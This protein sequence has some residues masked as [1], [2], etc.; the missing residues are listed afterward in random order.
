MVQILFS[1][2]T[3]LFVGAV[4]ALPV[5]CDSR[6][7]QVSRTSSGLCSGHKT[8]VLLL[9]VFLDLLPGQL[10]DLLKPEWGG[11]NS[12]NVSITQR[13]ELGAALTASKPASSTPLANVHPGP[14]LSL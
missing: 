4:L 7:C 6:T 12:P 14:D 3:D 11:K 8:P 5:H 9:R 13:Y 2:V 1:E 10:D